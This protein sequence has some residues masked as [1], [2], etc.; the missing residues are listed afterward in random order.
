[1]ICQM[2]LAIG[3][4]MRT[5]TVGWRPDVPGKNFNDNSLAA[6]TNNS[7]QTGKARTLT[8]C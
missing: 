8:V 4:V 7:L 1:M 2:G 3:E 5:G 6:S